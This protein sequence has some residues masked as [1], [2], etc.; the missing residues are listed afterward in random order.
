MKEDKVKTDSLVV[1][2]SIEYE[3]VYVH[4]EDA[5]NSVIDENYHLIAVYRRMLDTR[6]LPK[7]SLSSE[8]S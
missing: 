8:F 1:D 3:I 7:K 4:D 5:A 6:R 2:S